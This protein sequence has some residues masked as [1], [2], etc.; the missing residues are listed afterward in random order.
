MA[1]FLVIDVGTSGL[2]AAV[3]DDTL[4]IVAFEYRVCPPE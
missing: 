2:R 1:Q 3:V 4:S